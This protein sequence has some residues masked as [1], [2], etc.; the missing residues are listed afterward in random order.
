MPTPKKYGLWK[1]EI[2]RYEQELAELK[3]RQAG[4]ELTEREKLR[5]RT[6]PWKLE[7]LYQRSKAEY[8]NAYQPPSII[9]IK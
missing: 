1:E 9:I 5:L 7:S 4:G 3:E 8:R 2:E 6:L